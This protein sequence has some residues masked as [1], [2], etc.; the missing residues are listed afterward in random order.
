M[1][2]V[3]RQEEADSGGLGWGRGEAGLGCGQGRAER[4]VCG[5][6]DVPEPREHHWSGQRLGGLGK[7][8]ILRAKSE[9]LRAKKN[10][11][12]AFPFHCLMSLAYTNLTLIFQD[13]LQGEWCVRVCNPVNH[14]ILPTACHWHF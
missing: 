5:G 13:S 8:C 3:A 11:S 2:D 10:A 9:F 12:S 6:G 1:E 14:A 4:R 7:D